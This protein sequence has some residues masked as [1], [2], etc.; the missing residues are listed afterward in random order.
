MINNKIAHWATNLVPRV[1]ATLVL[2]E[3]EIDW[4]TKL[5]SLFAQD[6]NLLAPCDRTW[7]FS[8]PV[9]ENPAFIQHLLK[10]RLAWLPILS[11]AQITGQ[12]F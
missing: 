1:C 11:Q 5:L 9:K 7:V 4:V 6:Q 12:L 10:N 8:C 3:N 2:S